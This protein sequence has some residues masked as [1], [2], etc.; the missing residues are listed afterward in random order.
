MKQFTYYNPVK[1]IFGLNAI[2]SLDLQINNRKALLITEKIFHS[3]GFVKQL[4]SI[5]KN[6]TSIIDIAQAMPTFESL[7]L[8]YKK[9]W[10]NNFD[11]IIALGGGS[12]IDSAKIVSVYR[13]SQQFSH[14]KRNLL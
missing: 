1:I 5:T 7:E 12:V 6:I 8:L 3:L 10:K 4:T 11:V 13:E 14:I 2:K 9:A